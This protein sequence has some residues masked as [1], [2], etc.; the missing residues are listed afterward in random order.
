MKQGAR[1]GKTDPKL[2]YGELGQYKW[3]CTE[4]IHFPAQST[5][6]QKIR[7]LIH[8]GQLHGNQVG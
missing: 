5:L 6:L 8:V 1:P 2:A 3:S 7:Y 4:K